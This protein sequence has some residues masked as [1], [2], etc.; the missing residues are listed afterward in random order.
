[1]LKWSRISLREETAVG[2]QMVTHPYSWPN[3][4][5]LSL[6]EMTSENQATI[7]PVADIAV[8]FN[9]DVTRI[10]PVWISECCYS[11]IS[12]LEWIP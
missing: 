9:M 11:S 4:M 6:D 8:L 12:D 3:S 10:W 2:S 7:H 5:S 1:M